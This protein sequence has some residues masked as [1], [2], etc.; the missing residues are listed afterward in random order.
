[1]G[2]T[3]VSGPLHIVGPDLPD[4][5]AFGV[6]QAVRPFG[7]AT[8]VDGVATTLLTFTIPNV[9]AS[10][11]ITVEVR[12]GLTTTGH[13]Y[14]STRT[15]NQSFV[16]TRTP[17]KA[18]VAGA[19][20]AVETQIATVSSGTTFTATLATAAVVG[21]ATATNT[22]ALQITATGGGSDTF[23]ADVFYDLNIASPV[24]GVTIA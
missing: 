7:G 5:T 16:F 1:M 21:A 22:I 11:M 10:F 18:A 2:T 17:G 4:R 12:V 8:I 20:T 9:A 13:K 3:H 15:I 6:S 19:A 23:D 14:D 24:E